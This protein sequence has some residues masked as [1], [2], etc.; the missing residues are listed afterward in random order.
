MDSDRS[1]GRAG[2]P[3]ALRRLPFLAMAV[4]ALLA[5]L[6]AG[7]LRLGLDLPALRP[8]LAADHGILLVLGFLGTQI[9]LERA[10]AL[11]RGWTYLAPAAAGA[12]ALWLLLGLPQ[13]AGQAILAF[14]G[15]VLVAV[16]VAVHRIQPSWHNLVMGLGAVAWLVGAVVWMADRPMADVMP[17][18]AAFLVLTIVGERLELSRM[19]RPP[20]GAIALLLGVVAAFLAGLVIATAGP[21]GAGIRLAGIGLFGQALWLARYD[22]ARRTIRVAGATRYMAVA[23]IAGYFWLGVAG[24][25][26]V[27]GGSLA[28]GGFF[29][30]AMVHTIFLGFV[31]SM[32]FAHAAIIVPAVLGVALPWRPGFYLPLAL[33]HL[34]L[35]V[36]VLGD[37]AESTTAWRLGGILDEIAILL[38]LAMAV[39]S[40]VRAG[41]SARST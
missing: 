14:G 6:W 17:W 13:E 25:S 23:L 19:G 34:G 8:G 31:F 35:A 16:F 41:R 11:G 18:L 12:G 2:R 24:I 9:G 20:K 37:L 33:L 21:A 30:D 10:V 27:A 26:W 3:P 38:F 36:R 1:P 7:L 29:Y 5:G 39:V 32:I 28:G 22:V 4:V 15:L 40:S